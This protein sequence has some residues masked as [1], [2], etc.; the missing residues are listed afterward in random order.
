M[1]GFIALGKKINN[2]EKQ[3]EQQTA[4]QKAKKDEHGKARRVD[5]EWTGQ[6]A[7]GWSCRYSGQ[8]DRDSF[9]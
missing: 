9:L 7:S 1:C 5:S 3:H 2:K 6:S 8:Q 4:E